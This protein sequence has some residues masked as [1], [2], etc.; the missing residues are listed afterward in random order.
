MILLVVW[1]IQFLFAWCL[2]FFPGLLWNNDGIHIPSGILTRCIWLIGLF[3]FSFTACWISVACLI[4]H[5]CKIHILQNC[6]VCNSLTCGVSDLMRCGFTGSSFYCCEC[7]HTPGPLMLHNSAALAGNK[8]TSPVPGLCK[9]RFACQ[10]CF[11]R[12]SFHILAWKIGDHFT[13]C[14]GIYMHVWNAIAT[15]IQPLSFTFYMWWLCLG[16][17]L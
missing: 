10:Q 4:V 2:I 11:W 7:M 8:Q 17:L 12:Q 15:W 14:F 6:L 1:K 9:A 16:L 5:A 3:F 13:M